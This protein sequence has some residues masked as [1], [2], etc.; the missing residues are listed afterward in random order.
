M[1]NKK[2][3]TL[4]IVVLVLVILA[5]IC[6]ATFIVRHVDAYSYYDN[7]LIEEYDKKIVSASG[8]SKN[9]SMFF[10]D[11]AAVKSKVEKAFPDVEVI[12]VKRS[13]PDRVTI[14]Y[15]IYEKSFQYQ[16]GDKYYQCYSSG[17]IGSA[18]D[19]KSAGYFTIK[20]SSATSTTVGSYFQSG[21]GR[22]RRYVDA[23]IKF[24]RSKG[25]IDFQI[26]QFIN[27]IDFR[28]NGYVYIRTN[29]GCSIEIHD[30]GGA[31]FNAM[32]ERGFAVYSKMDPQLTDIRQTQGLIK[33]YPNLSQGAD[34]PVRCV[35][36]RPLQDEYDNKVYTDEG[37]YTR[38]YED[39]AQGA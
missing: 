32:L 26:N 2:L 36:L 37:Y 12:N 16:N 18:S 24:L 22:D 3:I 39:V 27:F 34:D 33:V 29:A 17:R 28:R 13:F 20:P 6:G 1:R 9:G 19:V 14:N 11:E 23:I 30:N 31:D 21:D 10:V 15:V 25:L 7:L 4:L 38:H 35:Y 8:V 5:I